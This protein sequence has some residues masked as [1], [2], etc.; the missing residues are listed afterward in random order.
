M[1]ELQPQKIVTSEAPQSRLSG[2]DIAQP[3][4]SLARGLDALGEGIEKNAEPFAEQAGLKSVSV[5]DQGNLQ[6][7]HAPI[8]GEAGAAYARAQKFSALS[9]GQAEA[10]RQDLDISTK[11]ANDPQGY[12]TAAKQ[13]RQKLIDQYSQVSPEVGM[14]LGKS[15]DDQTSYNYRFLLLAQQRQIRDNFD[16]NSKYKIQ[17]NLE[18]VENLIKTGAMDNPEGRKLI[19]AKLDENYQ[20]HHERINNPILG[21]PADKEAYDL[22]AANERVGAA[23]FEAKL[24]KVVDEKGGLGKAREM[25]ENELAN[26]SLSPGQKSINYAHGLAFIKDHEQNLQ[27]EAAM[28]TTAQKFKDQMFEDQVIKGTAG[29]G[30]RVLENDIKTAPDVSPESK[31]RMLAWVR[32]DGLPEP[33]SRISSAK[34]IDL[35][36]RMNLP[37]GDPN[38]I[39]DMS[40][41]REAYAPTDGT[42]GSLT[43]KDEEWLEKRFREDRSPEGERLTEIRQQ[44]NHAVEPMIDHSNPLLGKAGLDESG[45][46]QAYRFQRFVDDQIDQY[47]KAGK[48]PFDLFNPNK[49]DYL[50]D[51]K[52][53]KD[54]Q[55][56]IEESMKTIAEKFRPTTPATP[57]PQRQ[58]GESV[59]DFLKR[60]GG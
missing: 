60:T 14:A 2:S 26:P 38:K 42:K 9:Q 58:P 18:D 56:K 46:L 29:Q 13:F 10:K 59:T 36:R 51:Q 15:I 35:F 44:F 4:E 40:P 32:R 53:L 37:D 11:F 20:L 57:K 52:I 27:R 21:A 12:L 23:M 43:I 19:K 33:D 34:A 7:T 54:Y 48:N 49:P 55:V 5:D 28:A 17:S 16:T 22:K 50:G 47:R 24:Q 25:V 3:F 45:K 30:P 41:I 1:A 6:V 8:F 39:T 31:M